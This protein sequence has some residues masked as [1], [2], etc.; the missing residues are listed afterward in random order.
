MKIK[1]CG[2]KFK[3][4]MHDI[5]M[6]HPDYMGFIF[7]PLSKRCMT[8]TLKP[9]NL[10]C[11]N[12]RK[13]GVFVDQTKEEIE[14]AIIAF[15]LDLIQLHGQETP[16]FCSYFS[17]RINV[18]KAFSVDSNF[19]FNETKKYSEV[20]THFLFDTKGKSKGGNGVAFDWEILNTYNQDIP[21]FLSGGIGLQNIE[22]A[23]NL[24]NLN[25]Y[26]LDINS[27]VE[28]IPGYKN[29]EQVKQIINYLRAN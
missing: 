17:D 22:K 16:K 28:D 23:I 4:N 19:N 18:I 6:L 20:C 11:I 8:G 15:K 29:V 2:M 21:F 13:T 1:I 9:E 7:Y 27:K 12:A 10:Q 5:E 14:A 25:I 3:D 26:G 24:K